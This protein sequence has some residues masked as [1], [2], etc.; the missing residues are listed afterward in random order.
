M[1]SSA[2][3]KR[4]VIDILSVLALLLFFLVPL[5]A[6][7]A[8]E[9]EPNNTPAQANP[10]SLN[11]VVKGFAHEDED[12]DWY[13]LTIP[14]PGLDVLVFELSTPPEV[15]LA[16]S[17]C[18]ASGEELSIMDAFRAG[19]PETLVRLRQAAGKFRDFQEWCR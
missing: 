11:S 17:F 6:Q 2:I 8:A 4:P 18:D 16:L 15:N 12:D 9:Q 13:L 3:N 7:E 10:L 14:A 1:I 5:S 19:E